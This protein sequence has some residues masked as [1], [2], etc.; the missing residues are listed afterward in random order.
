VGRGKNERESKNIKRETMIDI[1]KSAKS[2]KTVMSF[3]VF[4]TENIVAY[5]LET[6]TAEPEK[7]P[8]LVNGSETTF[9][10]GKRSL[11]EQVYSAVAG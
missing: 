2:R 1:S 8:L 6:R 5:L 9:V 11:N 3:V 4:A 10:A 7:Q